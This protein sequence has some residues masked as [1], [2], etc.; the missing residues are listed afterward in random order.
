MVEKNFREILDQ[1][2]ISFIEENFNGLTEI[3]K[4]AIPYIL[5]GGD[6]IIEAPTA[7]GKTEAV[8]FPLLSR[9]ASN[10]KNS[11]QILYLAPLKALLN[12]VAQ[13]VEKYSELCGLRYVKWH[14][15]V[16]QS[17]KV[18]QMKSPPQVMLTT[19]ESL[20][21]ILLRKARWQKFFEDLEVV[22][23][24]EAHN[25]AFGDRGCHLLSL[26]E[27][28]E[29][30]IRNPF[31]RIAMTATIG[32]PDRMLSWLAGKRDIGARL[33][34]VKKK[35]KKRDFKVLLFWNNVHRDLDGQVMETSDQ[36]IITVLIKLLYG[37]KS[38]VFTTSRNKT[39][40]IAAQINKKIERSF[41][42][43]ELKIRTHH[44][45]V[46]KF[47]REKAES[48][49]QIKSDDALNGIISTCTLELGI[50]IG[51]L[52]RVIQIGSLN[53][54]ASFLQRVGRTGRRKDT[55]QYFRGICNS[56][57]DL[58][59]LSAVVNLGLKEESEAF[60]F[61][62]KAFHILAHQIICLSLQNHGV[63][64]EE[65][66]MTFCRAYCFSGISRNEFDLLIDAMVDK[67][68]LRWVEGELV[69]GEATEKE[70][71]VSNWR[72]LFAVFDSAPMYEVLEG[73]NQV[74][75]L[76]ER[77]VES[78]SVPFIFVL[79]GIDWLAEK[80]N[81]K[82]RQVIAKRAQ[83]GNAPKWAVYGINDVPKET[84]LE[85]GR[86]LIDDY[87]PDF[88][89]ENGRDGLDAERNR[90]HGLPWCEKKWVV[91]IE[92]SGKTNIWTF[93]GDKLNR[94]LSLLMQDEALG[95]TA[96]NYRRVKCD[97]LGIGKKEMK[98]LLDGF[99][100]RLRDSNQVK[101]NELEE[102]LMLHIPKGMRQ[103]FSN[104]LTVELNNKAILERSIDLPGLVVELQD[105][106]ICFV[107]FS[108]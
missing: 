83:A 24:D 54:P 5:T 7:G 10:K 88:L 67:K 69:V 64:R 95:T 107:D 101:I 98:S 86:I 63:T 29:N 45:S 73:K 40:Q 21:A 4:I 36:D 42:L 51:E 68:Y 23:I 1:R 108:D 39:E 89:D 87:Y 94:T 35:D 55:I 82:T 6:C 20:E 50:D 106:T 65:I 38:I 96:S 61:P 49:I 41:A 62:R 76:D 47:F 19:P 33:C 60:H 78:V 46:S 15:D 12:N 52:D 44:S 77:F 28:L 11:I 105:S 3:Q 56:S 93:L 17:E 14:G 90:V 25:F 104:C 74:G 2:I 75:T 31:Q 43:K 71:L 102:K 79:G 70:L 80:V 37:K 57:A 59:V 100:T 34:A 9:I 58:L 13:R 81:H 97:P 18:E 8:F 22:I 30:G 92:S 72:R 85:V 32:N 103:K 26:L 27:R 53:S 91:A 66:W 99:F 84:A 16:G 48:Q